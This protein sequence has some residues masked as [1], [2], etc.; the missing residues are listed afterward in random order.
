MIYLEH[1]KKPYQPAPDWYSC[2]GYVCDDGVHTIRGTHVCSQSDFIS[3]KKKSGGAGEKF[4]ANK[5][6]NIDENS[7][8]FNFLYK[9]LVQIF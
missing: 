8:P 7:H 6:G 4:L 9:A 5:S 1:A 3:G 2:G